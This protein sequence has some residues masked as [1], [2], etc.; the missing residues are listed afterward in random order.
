[1]IDIADG[2]AQY[3]YQLGVFRAHL[4]DGTIILA[5]TLERFATIITLTENEISDLEQMKNDSIN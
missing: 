4:N 5:P 1:M 3:D 2:K